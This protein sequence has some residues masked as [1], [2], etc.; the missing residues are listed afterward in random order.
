M[1]AAVFGGPLLPAWLATAATA[2][3]DLAQPDPVQL[4]PVALDQGATDYRA[5]RARPAEHVQLP[6]GPLGR[7][8]VDQARQVLGKTGRAVLLSASPAA[9]AHQLTWHQVAV[10]K[11]KDLQACLH[12]LSTTTTTPSSPSS[13]S[14]P[15]PSASAS[16]DGC[17]DD[18]D[19][20]EENGDV[21]TQRLPPSQ[22]S[23]RAREAKKKLMN[24]K[25]AKEE[26]RR[27]DAASLNGQSHRAILLGCEALLARLVGFCKRSARPEQTCAVVLLRDGFRDRRALLWSCAVPSTPM[28][29][30]PRHF[31]CL[32]VRVVLCA[33]CRVCHVS[34]AVC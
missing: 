14:S 13:S 10:A 25:K 11:A 4:S 32:A 8:L 22:R 12:L 7:V 30:V 20:E 17:D 27:R 23:I 18:G 24:K 3:A 19:D 33:V 2:A 6:R 16:Q 5:G 26:K 21:G 31:L 28:L 34:C 29:T 9:A 1:H 15:P